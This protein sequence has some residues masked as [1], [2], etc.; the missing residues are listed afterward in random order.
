MASQFMPTASE[1]LYGFFAFLKA[2]PSDP[3]PDHLHGK[4]LCG[5]IW[6]YSGPPEHA[7]AA[8]KPIRT[9]RKPLLEVVGPMPYTAMQSL[10]DDLVPSGLQWYWKGH[11][12]TDRPKKRS[13]ATWS[14]GVR[15]RLYYRRCTFTRSTE[16]RLGLVGGNRVQ[17]S[18]SKVL[19]G[20]LWDR[21]GSGERRVDHEMDK[22]LLG[23]H[24][25]LI[26]L[27]VPM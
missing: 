2:Q 6:C 18:G 21:S 25:S 12:M 22:R 16:R 3:F 11:F 26:A 10:F 20:H 5:I 15:S 19:Y 14:L 7:D 23:C 4:T 9:Y 8:F 13:I 24:R 17:L 1:D 27:E